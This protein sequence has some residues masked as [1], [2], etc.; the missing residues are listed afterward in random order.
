MQWK[1]L[2]S[3]ALLPVFF[4]GLLLFLVLIIFHVNVQSSAE[5]RPVPLIENAV[6]LDEQENVH[7]PL[8]A[9]LKIPRVNVD[10]AIDSMSLTADG[11]MEAPKGSRNVGWYSLGP[12][13]GDIGSAV[14]D[15]HSGRWKNGEGS[16]FDDL[17]KLKKG[18]SISVE[19]EKGAI[20][21]FVVRESREY[22]P[23]ADAA[24]V[25]SSDDE[26]SHLNLITCEGVWNKDAKSYSQRLVVFA[27]KEEI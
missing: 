16:V 26:Q 1:S 15:G 9:R 25:F 22:D 8:P 7:S 21:L 13:P 4:S 17:N 3:R 6:A 23:N 12:H 11:A 2:S 5:N 19:D 18:D 27:D 24:D 14:I 10:A 20:T